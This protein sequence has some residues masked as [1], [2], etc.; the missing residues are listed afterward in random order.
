MVIAL[1]GTVGPQ[2]VTISEVHALAQV[3]K[4]RS[5]PLGVDIETT[6]LNIYKHKIVMLQFGTLKRPYILDCR[7]FYSLSEEDKEAWCSIVCDLLASASALVGHNVKFDYKFLRSHF[8]VQAE[9]FVDTM[10]LEQLILSTGSDGYKDKNTG[11]KLI[12]TANRYGI[13]M[14]KDLQK[15]SVD[16]DQKPEWHEPFPQE[17]LDYGIMDIAVPLTIFATQ[18]KRLE[19]L[20]MM[21]VAGLEMA[22][23]P[24]FVDMEIAGCAINEERWRNIVKR[25]RAEKNLME[26]DIT[27]LLQPCVEGYRNIALQEKIALKNK[28]EAWI[29]Q[30]TEVA[31]RQYA[32]QFSEGTQPLVSMKTFVDNATAEVRKKLS[33][34]KGAITRLQNTYKDLLNL[35]SVSQLLGALHYLGVPVESTRK[36]NLQA[37]LDEIFEDGGIVAEYEDLKFDGKELVAELLKYKT[38]D[39]FTKAFGDNILGTV[40]IPED[41]KKHYKPSMVVRHGDVCKIHPEYNQIG[42]RTGRTSCKKPNWQQIPQDDKQHPENSIRRCIIAA[43]GHKLIICDLP[44]IELRIL[45]ELSKDQ[46]LL[47]MFSEGKDVHSAAT[48]DMF[49]LTVPG[50][51]EEIEALCKVNEEF[52]KC[53]AEGREPYDAVARSTYVGNKAARDIGKQLDFSVPYGMGPRGIAAKLRISDEEAEKHYNTYFSTFTGVKEHLESVSEFA[54]KYGYTSTILGRKRFYHLPKIE[55]PAYGDSKDVKDA[56]YSSADWAKYKKARG[57]IMREAKNAGIQGTNADIIKLAMVLIYQELPEGCS[58]IACIH[59][60]LIVEAPDEWSA[61]V[62]E[63]VARGMKEACTQFLKL[64][65]IP[66]M[67]V[68]I[69]DY[70]KK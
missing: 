24:V 39:K 32:Q 51:P 49:D 7:P 14:S 36:D 13:Q 23:L 42:A 26:A 44:N 64:V 33:S 4:N 29:A 3:L 10:I 70:W 19:R 65:A 37:Y 68:T 67:D 57:A 43:P 52:A 50:T 35:N 48:C 59:D 56:F 5:V 47:K 58:I 45:A 69:S 16:L 18:Y 20:G 38:I 66:E 61:I 9:R 55:K 40:G 21:P 30:A 12:A 6:G 63:I 46:A 27:T 22:V 1:Q 54:L 31:Q 25:R 17:F 53:I 2:L 8:G 15:W 11:V 34:T 28:Y 41:D 62:K 60:E